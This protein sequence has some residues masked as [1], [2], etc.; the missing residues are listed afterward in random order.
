M[1]VDKHHY[2]AETPGTTISSCIC[3][4][5]AQAA[6][7][8]TEHSAASALLRFAAGPSSRTSSFVATR[9]SKPLSTSTPPA[10]TPWLDNDPSGGAGVAAFVEGVCGSSSHRSCRTKQGIRHTAKGCGGSIALCCCSRI[11]K[12]SPRGASSVPD[13]SKM[14]VSRSRKMCLIQT[15]GT[16]TASACDGT[17]YC[18]WATEKWNSLRRRLVLCLSNNNYE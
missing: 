13:C 12:I 18:W 2:C 17:F 16:N 3:I 7:L 14:P 8:S 4:Y 10:S 5:L 9:I 15:M 6:A 11:P 1:T